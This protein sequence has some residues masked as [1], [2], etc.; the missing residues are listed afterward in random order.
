MLVISIDSITYIHIMS[1]SMPPNS[2]KRKIIIFSGMSGRASQSL[3]LP[4]PFPSSLLSQSIGSDSP[5]TRPLTAA[6][7]GSGSRMIEIG[8]AGSS[9][10][11]STPS[12]EYVCHALSVQRMN[13]NR[14]K[15]SQKEDKNHK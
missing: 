14:K 3:P 10:R 8:Q 7:N 13:P 12:L 5:A 9:S 1:P 2:Q 15:E 6:F 4:L 11:L